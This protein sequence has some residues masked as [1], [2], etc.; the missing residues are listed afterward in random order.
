MEDKTA[1]VSS[2][3]LELYDGCSRG[4]TAR[5]RNQDER[6]SRET[7]DQKQLVKKE[8]NSVEREKKIVL[9]L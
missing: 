8:I 3:L 5:S 7:D 9:V 1:W 6:K 2:L 4:A